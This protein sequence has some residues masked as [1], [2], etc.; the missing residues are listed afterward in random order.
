MPDEQRSGRGSLIDS[1]TPEDA[2]AVLRDLSH[3]RGKLADAVN[4]AIA[5]YLQTV[6]V[7]DVATD[8]F[9]TLDA[10]V[11]EDVWDRSGRTR[12]G[13]TEPSQAAVDVFEEALE[14]FIAK[15]NE[16]MRLEMHSEAEKYCLGILKGIYDFDHESESNYKEWAEDVPH[17]SFG[18]VRQIWMDH[19][20]DPRERE[21]MDARIAAICPGWA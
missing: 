17:E 16:Y 11:V 18:W 10:L 3:G 15:L 19:H 9:H 5:A 12:Y 14:P 1:L 4:D 8:I 7:E 13:Y 6:D 2:L 20:R 21:G